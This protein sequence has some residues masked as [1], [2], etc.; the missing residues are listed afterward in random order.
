MASD[1]RG[2]NEF[3]VDCWNLTNLHTNAI[4][5]KDL[6]NVLEAT[7]SLKTLS[8]TPRN[9]ANQAE[10]VEYSI[11]QQLVSA[12]GSFLEGL[13]LGASITQILEKMITV[14]TLD[15]NVYVFQ[16]S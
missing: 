5:S 9:L 16:A 10:E 12:Q 15:A 7:E 3:L 2:C 13:G 11:A 1:A 8:V 6:L 14:N 4:E